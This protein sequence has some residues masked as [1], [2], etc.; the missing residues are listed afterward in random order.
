MLKS[1]IIEK[2]QTKHINLS[3]Y[4]IELILKIFFKKIISSLNDGNTI[5]IRGFGTFKK[6]INKEKQVRNPKNNQL[7]FKEQ[8]YKMH[9]KTGKTLHKKLNNISAEDD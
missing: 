9:F 4:D 2:L 7:I 6:K 5:E 8:T 1:E 3:N